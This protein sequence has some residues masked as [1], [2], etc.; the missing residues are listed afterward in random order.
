MNFL[1]GVPVLITTLQ[2]PSTFLFSF[3]FI[4]VVF[5]FFSLFFVYQPLLHLFPFPFLSLTSSYLSFPL[6]SALTT[7]TLDFVK[8]L[9]NHV[10]TS[11]RQEKS[12]QICRWILSDSI[13]SCSQRLEK[14]RGQTLWCQKQEIQFWTLLATYY[15]SVWRWDKKIFFF[16]FC[17]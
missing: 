16:V 3:C 9:A 8:E 1:L 6:G 10:S 17:Y 13:F 14:I 11:E 4:F 15:L 5:L 2:S 7:L 12:V